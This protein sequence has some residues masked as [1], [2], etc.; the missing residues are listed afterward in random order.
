MP[1]PLS[2][3]GYG[4]AVQRAKMVGDALAQDLNAA[5]RSRGPYSI[6]IVAH[7]LGCRVA[8]ETLGRLDRSV[9]TAH[10]LFFQ[11]AALDVRRMMR[12]GDNLLLRE[13]LVGG[14]MH[15]YSLSSTADLVLRLAFAGGQLLAKEASLPFP[16][17]LG[18]HIWR[19]RGVPVNMTQR[20]IVGAGHSDYWGATGDSSRVAE[21]QSLVRFYL[22]LRPLAGRFLPSRRVTERPTEPSRAKLSRATAM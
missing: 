4:V 8:L 17:A 21:A 19:D 9:V 10:Y 14:A 3:I 15:V 20:R 13:S 1:H 2:A 12:L 5:A 6:D 18:L 16:T 11:A 22:G 7:S